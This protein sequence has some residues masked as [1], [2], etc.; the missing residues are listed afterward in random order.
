MTRDEAI[1]IIKFNLGNRTGTELD[2][3]IVSRLKQAQRLLEQGRSLPYFLKYEDQI[4]V[5]PGEEFTT[6][7]PEGFL[8]EAPDETFH[9]FEQPAGSG[10]VYLKKLDMD[11]G[12]KIFYSNAIDLA[13]QGPPVAYS[14][15]KDTVR[16][17]PVA[18]IEYS[19][20][21]TY[22]KSGGTLDSN[23]SDNAW[24][25][26]APDVLIG[27]AGSLIAEVIAHDRAKA[28]FDQMFLAAW[29]NAFAEGIL[30]EEENMP[31]RMG[32]RL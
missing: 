28:L 13:A 26:N 2:D 4:F 6:T 18:D 9:R 31:L 8:R 20:E 29:N 5:I 27:R 22:Y 17:Y 32:A 23:V 19:L 25:V 21:Y 14:L 3:A 12:F 16:F 11:V 24:L 10:L 1:A 30:R 7:L 15:R